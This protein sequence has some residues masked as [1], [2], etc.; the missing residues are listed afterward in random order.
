MNNTP[1]LIVE[2]SLTQALQLQNILEGHD[3]SVAVAYNGVEALEHLKEQIPNL[4]ISDIVM[5]EMDGYELCKHIRSDEKFRDIP[6]ILLTAL[7]DPEDVI[8]ALE[9]GADNFV[10]KPYKEDFLISRIRTI[11]ANQELRKKGM[12]EMGIEIFFGGKKIF[13]TSQRTQIIDLLLSTYEN[14]IQK[15]LELKQVNNELILAHQELEKR[16]IQLQKLN[17]QKNR[18]LGM[19]AHDLRNPLGAISNFSEVLYDESAKTL[20]QEQLELVSTIRSSSEFMLQMVNDFLDISKIESGKL[21]LNLQP[22]D[23]L[24]LAKQNIF[25]NR[26]FSTKKG[27]ELVLN[28]EGDIP[29]MLLDADKIEQ[30]LNNFISNAVKFSY[31]QS[32]IKVQINRSDDHLVISVT[33]EGQ[34]IPEK[35]LDKLFNAFE[36]TSVKTTGGEKSTGLGLSIVKK[37]AEGHKGKIRV[38]SEV[39]KGSTFY[40]SLPIIL[41]D[42]KAEKSQ[43]PETMELSG[44][45]ILLAEDNV[46]NQRMVTRILEKQRCTVTIAGTGKEAVSAFEKEQFDLILMDIQMPEMDGLAATLEI[47]Q[48]STINN[49]QSTIQRV[50]IIAMTGHATEEESEKCL[51]AGIDDFVSKPIKPGMVFDKIQ[52]WAVKGK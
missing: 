7:S 9:C 29:V 42:K 3:Y 27:I 35:D 52:K 26:I 33:D 22:T 17:E 14:A 48:Q 51:E 39:G 13:I 15:N 8:R 6:V 32:V 12:S 31:P 11:L 37:I 18:F 21:D 50:P 43:R 47:R 20:N 34:G 46:V 30:V 49:Q 16:N 10:I 41:P 1:I 28:H 19:A 4:V 44:L 40:A 24:S 2:D 36:Q 5:P 25:L 38:E 23:I 45:R